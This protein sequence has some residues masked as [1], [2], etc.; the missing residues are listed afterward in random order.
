M[1]EI[2]ITPDLGFV[3]Q[4]APHS[5]IFPPCHAIPFSTPLSMGRLAIREAS[6]DLPQMIISALVLSASVICSTPA[7][8]T[9]FV[10]FRI[11]LE[12]ILGALFN[13]KSFF[14]KN[15]LLIF[16]FD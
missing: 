3:V 9:M 16:L 15:A 12:D 5:P 7:S 8:P 11:F 2:K 4:K 1:K 13:G 6:V 14:F 10:Q